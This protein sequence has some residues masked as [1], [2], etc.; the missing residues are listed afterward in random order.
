MGNLNLQEPWLIWAVVLGVGFPLLVIVLGEIIQRL[1]RQKNPIAS[2]LR[3]VKNFVLPS[4]AVMVFVRDVLKLD[5]QGTLVKVIQTLFWISVIN[6]VLSLIKVLLF[7]EAEKDSW[8][9]R[10]PKLLV[11]LL[12]VLSILV[13]GAIVLSEVWGADLAGIATAL[14]VTS[15]VIGLALQEPLGSV[16]TGIMLLFERPFGIGD[17]LKVGEF[18]GQVID[19]NWRAVRLLTEDRQVYIVPHQ[20]LGKE[21][22]CNYTEPN[23]IFYG[24]IKVGFSYD[25]PPNAVKQVLLHTALSVPGILAEPEPDCQT[26]SYDDSTIAYEVGFFV[27]DFLQIASAQNEFMTRIWYAARRNNLR[28]NNYHDQDPLES[29]ASK[30]D[31]TATKVSQ[32]FSSIP[33]VLAVSKDESILDQLTKGTTIQHFGKGETA[34]WQG[35]RVFSMYIII[36]GE[37]VMTVLNDREPELE[38]LKLSKGDFFG[39]MALFS[40][41]PSPVSV[42]AV[43]DMEVL[44]I[45]ADA[46]NAILERQPILSREIAQVIEMRKQAIHIAQRTSRKEQEQHQSAGSG[47]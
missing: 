13:G 46:V 26:I 18:E 39:V 34:I 20:L 12:R 2:T 5:P 8:R 32:G 41:Q 29:K 30:M 4:S 7:E 10:M 37:A 36:S 27:K 44:E 23:R 25:N 28:L 17:W 42:R 15:I 43:E 35:N 33:A 45:E 6:A 9:G 19:M 1:K 24:T 47:I 31:L 14:G 38:I 40:R 16:F 21:V 22:I 3:T 11:D